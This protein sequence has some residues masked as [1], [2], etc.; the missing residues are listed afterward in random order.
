MKRCM[1]IL[2]MLLLTTAAAAPSAGVIVRTASLK[3]SP[4]FSAK[5]LTNLAPGARVNVLE[6]QGGWQNVSLQASPNVKG[7]VRT[8][9]VRVD[10]EPGTNPAVVKNKGSDGGVLG[11]LTGLSRASAGLFGKPESVKTNSNDMV[12]TIGVR[13]LSEADLKKAKPNPKELEKL[14]QYAVDAATAKAYAQ[15]GKL[16]SQQVEA[17]AEAEPDKGKKK[18]K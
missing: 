16:K 18:K 5:P 17:L 7:W 10:I 6:R 12:A 13:G 2:G 8:Y 1:W 4:S 14:H 9:E 3:D 11:G 15:T